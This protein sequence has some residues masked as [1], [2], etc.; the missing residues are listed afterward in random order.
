M[1]FRCSRLDAGHRTKCEVLGPVSYFQSVEGRKF[2]LVV[3]LAPF[4]PALNTSNRHSEVAGK[5]GDERVLEFVK[6]VVEYLVPSGRAITYL[7]DY[8]DDTHLCDE[9][10]NQGLIIDDIWD[11]SVLYPKQ[12]LNGFKLAQEVT[13][14]SDLEKWLK[15][16][17][18]ESPFTTEKWEDREYLGFRMKFFVFKKSA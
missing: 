11:P 3:F 15:A 10:K 18:R 2:H 8:V 9:A 16:S 13:L 12:P 6:Q 7:P 17:G 4:L 5:N 1:R 14:R